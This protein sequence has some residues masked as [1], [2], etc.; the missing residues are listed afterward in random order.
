MGPIGGG[1]RRWEEGRRLWGGSGEG[2]WRSGQRLSG[3][4]IIPEPGHPPAVGIPGGR[5]GRRAAMF[6]LEVARPDAGSEQ[7]D[8]RRLSADRSATVGIGA[9]PEANHVR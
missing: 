4:G 2:P 7:G 9:A 5:R 3:I 1:R 6:C 8:Q